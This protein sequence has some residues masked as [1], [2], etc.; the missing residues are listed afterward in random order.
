MGSTS[1]FACIMTMISDFTCFFIISLFV[2]KLFLQM[3]KFSRLRYDLNSL[4]V[5][6]IIFIFS[7]LIIPL[8][9]FLRI[10]INFLIQ[11][12]SLCV[13]HACFLYH[14]IYIL[15]I[16]NNHTKYDDLLPLRMIISTSSYFCNQNSKSG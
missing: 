2:L 4:F 1:V 12:L 6:V 15:L 16:L 13:H 14:H 9:A 7:R 8:H 5:Y 11:S 3:W 10:Q